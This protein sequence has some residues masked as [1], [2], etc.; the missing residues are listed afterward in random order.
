MILYLLTMIGHDGVDPT[1]LFF[2]L[3]FPSSLDFLNYAYN[4][5][6]SNNK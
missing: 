4:T 2:L 3:I 5:N 1:D 6:V